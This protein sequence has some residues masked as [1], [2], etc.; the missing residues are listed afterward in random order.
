VMF[1]VAYIGN[2]GLKLPA[3]RNLNQQPVVF[4]AAGA[5][6][7]GPRPLSAFGLNADI[8]LLENLGVSNYHSLQAKV[9]KRFSAGVSGLLSYTWGK[10][11]TNAVDHLSTSTGGNGVDVGVFKEAQD[12]NNRSAEYGLSEFDVQHRLIGSAVWQLPFGKG[13]RLSSLFDGWALSPIVT[14]QSGLGLTIVQSNL[15]NLG[16]ERQSRP[17]RIA[18]GALPDPQRTVDRYFDTSAFRILQTNPA[19]DGFVPLQA[20]GNSGVGVLRGPG[21]FNIDFNLS[22]NFAVTERHVLQFR[23][24]FF[25]ALNHPSFGVPGVNISSGGFGQIIQTATEARIIQLALKYKF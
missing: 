8:Q 14:V 10:S 12:G 17:N 9:E 5:P 6:G 2:R 18:N 4:N 11:L 24:E 1:E 15:L 22:R 20:F 23:A 19:L 3:F 16:G 25:N 7:A 21:L 13:R